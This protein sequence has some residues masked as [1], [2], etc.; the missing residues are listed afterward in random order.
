MSEKASSRGYCLSLNVK[1][2]LREMSCG[3]KGKGKKGGR[4]IPKKEDGITKCM[5]ETVWCLE[6]IT[7][8]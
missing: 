4:L 7:S 5:K 2:E 6:A 8:I 1:E 3:E